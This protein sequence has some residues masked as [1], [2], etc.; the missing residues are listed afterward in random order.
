[1]ALTKVD[2]D[3]D[4]G[5]VAYATGL[6]TPGVGS[7]AANK[8]YVDARVV[9]AGGAAVEVEVDFV[10]P[11]KVRTFSV[12]VTGVVVGDRVV[13][14]QSSDAPTGR[15]WD[16]NELEPLVCAASVTAANTVRLIVS[17]AGRAA[18]FG[19][20]KVA[21]AWKLGVPAVPVSLVDA[22]GDLLVGVADD[23]IVRLPV[24]PA[25]SVLYADP[26]AASGV[27]WSQ[28]APGFTPFSFTFTSASQGAVTATVLSWSAGVA[29]LTFAAAHA[30]LPGRKVTLAGFTPAGWNGDYTIKTTPSTT[31]ITVAKLDN[32]GAV[33]VFGTAA[34]AGQTYT[35]SASIFHDAA[36]GVFFSNNTIPVDSAGAYAVL[37]TARCGDDSG[38]F[39]NPANFCGLGVGYYDF[40]SNLIQAFHC[41]RVAGS[42]ETTL[43]ADLSPGAATATV[44]DATGWHNSTSGQLRHFAW[45]PYRDSTGYEFPNYSY[46]RN[47]TANLYTLAS[48]AWAS[49]GIAGN[50]ITLAGAWPGPFLPA[51]TPIAN[52]GDTENNVGMIVFPSGALPN[53]WTNYAA[54]I[55]PG[56]S[57]NTGTSAD[58]KLRYGTRRLGFIALTNFHSA[59]IN[60]RFQLGSSGV[61][62]L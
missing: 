25:T 15:S 20:Y 10:S 53:A 14:A 1:M 22:K 59:P 21:L 9:A 5:G 58:K 3:L 62:A 39:Y 12:A 19:K 52:F 56:Y 4:F 30:F 29:T 34:M 50:V 41:R 48:G 40:D 2:T 7:D 11:A 6:P 38:E 55:S 51:G 36:G 47:S 27:A 16:E 18:L 46:S 42:A 45:W 13:A 31:T 24:G 23:S 60:N 49:G 8:A 54:I 32:P 43:A 17:S 57:P 33:T 26:A 28:K 61:V 44:T 35:S 37:A